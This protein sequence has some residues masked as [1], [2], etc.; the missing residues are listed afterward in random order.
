MCDA[1]PKMVEVYRAENLSQAHAIRMCLEAAGYLAYVDS[2]L[3]QG[4][5]GELPMGW[6]TAPRVLVKESEAT[7]AREM[8][9]TIDVQTRTE[10]LPIALDDSDDGDEVIR[11]LACGNL[12]LENE[13]NCS[14]C[15]WSFLD[16][17][18]EAESAE[19]DSAEDTEQ[20]EEDR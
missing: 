8:L 1:E 14:S 13:A 3:L 20:S 7:A 16:P 2:E 5:T 9:L 18:A 19:N 12:M 17:G 6:V 4:V 15:G 11:C 10:S